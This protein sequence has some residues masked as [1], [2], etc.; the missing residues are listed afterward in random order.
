MDLYGRALVL[1]PDN[2]S[3]ALL[4]IPYLIPADELIACLKSSVLWQHVKKFTLKTNIFFVL[5]YFI[6]Y[7]FFVFMF[8]YKSTKHFPKQLLNI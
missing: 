2:F 7:I 1:S 5:V 3:Q 6:Y 4:V 8:N